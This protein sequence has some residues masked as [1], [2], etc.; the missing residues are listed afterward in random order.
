MPIIR[1]SDYVPLPI[2]VCPVVAVVKLESWVERCVHCVENVATGNILHTVHTSFYPT[3]QHHNSHDRTDNYRQWNVVGSPDD[4]HKDA[5]N[6]LRYYWLPINHYLLHLVGLYLLIKDAWSLEHKVYFFMC[7]VKF[8][9]DISSSV[10]KRC[11]SW[12][13]EEDMQWFSEVEKCTQIFSFLW[14][15][16]LTC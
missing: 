6:M 13:H 8:P 3:L 9:K 4:W 2:V 16:T 7:S 11:D 10:L 15:K 1:R 12:R 14:P 5:R